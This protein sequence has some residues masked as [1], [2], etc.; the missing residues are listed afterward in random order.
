[1]KIFD[2]LG[3]LEKNI[4]YHMQ[5]H[6]VLSSNLAHAETPGYKAKDLVFREALNDASQRGMAKTDIR[7]L[8]QGRQQNGPSFTTVE[9]TGNPGQDDNG[10]RLEK[11]M[12][13]V[14]ANRLRYETGIEIAR[15][16]LALLRYAATDGGR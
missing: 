16:R 11:A 4:S 13:Q 12:A 14:T 9:E 7:H 15:R 2:A 1:M 3:T 10:V 6:G 8:G 5:R